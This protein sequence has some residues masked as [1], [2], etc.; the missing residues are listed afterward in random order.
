[1]SGLKANIQKTKPVWI[2]CKKY[3]KD[4]HNIDIKWEFEE[5]NPFHFFF[6]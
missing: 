1:M 4:K 2:G 3:C 6:R 5:K